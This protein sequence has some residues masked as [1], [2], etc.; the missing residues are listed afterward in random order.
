[1]NLS[2]R[3]LQFFIKTAEMGNVSRAAEALNI[4][5]PGLTKAL[6]TL[7]DQLNI[8]L[9]TRTTRKL[10]LTP[11]GEKFLPVAKSL[12]RDLVAASKL[13]QSSAGEL[14]GAVSVAVGCAFGSTVLPAVLRTFSEFNPGVQVT[15]IED[16]ST[17]ITNRVKQGE[18]DLGIGSVF[19]NISGLECTRLL[20]AQLGILA[21]PMHFAIKDM[22][23]DELNALPMLRDGPD[24]SVMQ[25]LGL[26]GSPLVA[27]MR[28]GIEVT[29]LCLQLAMIKEG[30]GVAVLSSLAASHP[31][32]RDM[33]FLPLSPQ[34]RRDIFLQKSSDKALSPAAALLAKR[35]QQ[36]LQNNSS[37]FNLR[38][39][40]SFAAAKDGEWVVAPQFRSSDAASRNSS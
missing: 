12:L 19:G 16:T 37:S 14:Q 6:A 17:G 2:Q 4:T 36:H 1:M 27:Q 22:A 18:V 34:I 11:E 40:I 31:F 30:V 32:A 21:D 3:N 23:N 28:M 35:L 5:Q 39:G 7:E 26:A 10:V 15:V 13:F 20:T 38:K 24:S 29:S 9:F 8:L 25:M 33:H